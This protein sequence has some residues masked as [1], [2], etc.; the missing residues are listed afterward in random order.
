MLRDVPP[1][2]TNS[3][4]DMSIENIISQILID[5]QAWASYA[6]ARFIGITRLSLSWWIFYALRIINGGTRQVPNLQDYML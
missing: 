1:V 4:K 2:K 3:T 6:Q 5:K